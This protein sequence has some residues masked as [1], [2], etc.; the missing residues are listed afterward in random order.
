MKKPFYV[1]SLN[2]PR[3]SG[4]KTFMRLP[5]TTDLDDVDRSWLLYFPIKR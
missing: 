5:Y 4:I 2:Y 1:D 3:F